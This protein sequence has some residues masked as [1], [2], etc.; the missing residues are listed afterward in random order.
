MAELELD[1]RHRS[2]EK[3]MTIDAKKRV[4][5]DNRPALVRHHCAKRRSS[6]LRQSPAWADQVAIK[7]IYQRAKDLSIATGIEHHV[8]HIYPL[9]GKLVSGLHV[10]QN[11]QVL[12][13]TENIKKHNRYEVAP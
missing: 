2:R 11:L 10:H 13:A 1:K 7:E 5:Q 3:A 12:T 4:T 9:M 6:K 8:D